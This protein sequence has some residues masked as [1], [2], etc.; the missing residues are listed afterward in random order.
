MANTPSSASDATGDNAG[1]HGLGP[2]VRAQREQRGLTIASL[3]RMIGVSPAA[4]S[5]IESGT[6]QPSLTTL[7]KLAGAL[8]VPVFRFFLPDESD[9]VKVIRRSE[10]KTIRMPKSGVR[11]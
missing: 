5:Q 3:A 11:Y 9:A 7:R 6:V 8:G 2:A 4:V 1:D 10:R